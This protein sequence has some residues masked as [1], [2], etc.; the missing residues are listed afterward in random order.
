MAARKDH[1][2]KLQQEAMNLNLLIVEGLEN[3]PSG[4]QTR[5]RL[6]ALRR[7]ASHEEWE[8]ARKTSRLPYS[9]AWD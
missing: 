9:D 3:G 8:T 2:K 6:D 1:V 5:A 7:N 4:R